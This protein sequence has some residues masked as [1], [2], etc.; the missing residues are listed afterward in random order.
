MCFS[1]SQLKAFYP[2][3]W[4]CYKPVPLVKKSYAATDFLKA[5]HG[6]PSSSIIHHAN[7]VHS[8]SFM[9]FS[10]ASLM[11][12]LPPVFPRKHQSHFLIFRQLESLSLPPLCRLVPFFAVQLAV[13]AG[14]LIWPSLEIVDAV[15]LR[16]VMLP[17]KEPLIV[18]CCQRKVVH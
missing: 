16:V 4:N 3:H 7:F 15:E 5:L 1:S 14:G 2:Q 12:I 9:S 11:R 10:C 17:D 8:I 6:T 18:W 13:E